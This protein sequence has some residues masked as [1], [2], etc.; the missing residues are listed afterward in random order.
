MS[1]RFLQ[2]KDTESKEENHSPPYFLYL[3]NS[4]KNFLISLIRVASLGWVLMNSGTEAP[5]LADIFCQKV[6]A[7]LGLYPAM[8]IK[9]NPI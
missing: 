2:P 7:V 9:I 8:V 6:M 3:S 5:P 1:F 4:G